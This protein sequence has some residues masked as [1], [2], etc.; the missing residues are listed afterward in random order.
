MKTLYLELNM[1]AAGDM[2]MSA[3]Y[4]LVEDK[5]EF[6]D[7]IN[8][9]GY[10]N[11]EVKVN[12]SMKCGISGKNISIIVNGEEEESLDVDIRNLNH[13]HSY[14][15]S[16][17]HDHIHEHSHDHD[18]DHIHEHSH[19]HDHDHSHEHSHDHNHS[20]SHNS[21]TDVIEIINNFDL[22]DEIKENAISIY[23][24]IGEAESH[25]H[26]KSMEEVH[27]HE[28]GTID[29]IYD[30]VGNCILMDMINP[31]EIIA[32]SINL[33]NG[34]VKCQH[35]I[36]PVPAPATAYILKGVP[37]YKSSIKGELCTPTGAAILK[38][39]VKEFKEMPIMEVEKIG[40]GMGKK[41][42]EAPNCVRSFLGETKE[43]KDKLI[44]LKTTIDDMTGEE[45]GYLFQVLFNKGALEI[46]TTNIMM[47]KNR[48]GIEL[49][50]ISKEENKETI[51]KE[52]FSNTTT[53]GIKHYAIQR[54]TLE[55]TEEVVETE[56]GKIRK[57]ISK[58]FGIKREK[59]EYEDLIK[60]AENEN[61]SLLEVKNLLDK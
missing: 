10:E 21:Y 1:G 30:I 35:G 33:G 24:L 41:D 49:T 31:D 20:H 14:E 17:D 52:I 47:K 22:K 39:F 50:I 12:D 9:L 25:A 59:F 27:F 28:V 18:H 4:E 19:D 55:R 61:L 29:A 48:P 34:M 2:L 56:F 54:T 37:V 40:Y 5:E 15:H 44:E 8:S 58:G 26:N 38:H 3:L 13:D 36:M 32:S 57:K 6:L 23:K 7:K 16:H 60:I 43:S 46:Y 42:F 45:I 11:V 53:I 51:I